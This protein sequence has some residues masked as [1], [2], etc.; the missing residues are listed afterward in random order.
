MPATCVLV[1]AQRRRSEPISYVRAVPQDDGRDAH[2]EL[3]GEQPADTRTDRV[4][5]T[6]PEQEQ[7]AIEHKESRAT[8]CLFSWQGRLVG[9]ALRA[10]WDRST[11]LAFRGLSLMPIL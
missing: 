3:G 7:E 10:T 6:G 4:R 1:R 9:R 2:T 8:T 11:E 5:E